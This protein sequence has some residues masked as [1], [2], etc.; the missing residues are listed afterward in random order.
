MDGT[1]A[2]AY[3]LVD[4]Q[5][6]HLQVS[7]NRLIYM[8]GRGEVENIRVQQYGGEVIIRGKGTN[9]NALPQYDINKGTVRN[10]GNDGADTKEN[11]QVKPVLE[12][13]HRIMEKNTCIGYIIRNQLGLNKRFSREET[14]QLAE[15]GSIKNATVSHYNASTNNG[16]ST[17]ERKVLRGV[18]VQLDKL[19][20]LVVMPDGKLVDSRMRNGE[21]TMRVAPVPMRGI[22]R[23]QGKQKMF[24]PGDIIVVMPDGTVNI[25][26]K[27][28]ALQV[29]QKVNTDKATCDAYS[30]V[31][32]EY[33]I[34]FFG[35]HIINITPEMIRNWA[36]MKKRE[37]RVVAKA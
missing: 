3:D 33:T 5:G 36:V 28:K 30:K 10:A 22:L 27:E 31:Y 29:L 37:A 4:Q 35:K 13:T 19:P 14:L 2:V 12:I 1:T 20:S 15:S 25:L 18:N 6:T 32:G 8:V 7:K 17:E 34:E 9:I 26:A 11:T 21:L 23:F 16:L 24:N